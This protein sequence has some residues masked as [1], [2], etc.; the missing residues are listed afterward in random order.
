[1]TVFH[2]QSGAGSAAA[3]A[4]PA[5]VT[6]IASAFRIPAPVRAFEFAG[7]GNIN[8]QTY[9]VLDANGREYLLQRI[10][11]HV[12]RDPHSVMASM[13]ASIAAQN[14]NLAENNVP[15]DLTW[16]PIT[17][18]GARSGRPYLDVED[19]TLAGVW[20]LMVRIS[21]VL[22]VKSLSEIRSHD[23]RLKVA[24]EAGRGLAVYGDLTADMETAG[25]RSPLPGYRDTRLY[26]DQLQAALRECHSVEQAADLLPRDASLRASTK[27]LYLVDLDA[28]TYAERRGDERVCYMVDVAQRSERFAMTLLR[29]MDLGRIRRT[30]IHGDTKLENFLLDPH[31]LQVRA[32]I[33]LDTILPHTWLADWGDMVRSLVN[34]AGEKEP[35]MSCVDVD[36][37]IYEAVARGFL[38]AARRVTG[39]EVSLMVEAVEIIALELGVRFLTDYLRGDTYFRVGPDDPVDLNRTRALVQFTLFERLR[40]LAPQA[41]V[42]INKY[43]RF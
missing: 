8:Q 28:D 24:A 3:T 9:M 21:D 38:G 4:A 13:M 19:G 18:I 41:R 29:E 17:L 32:L 14:R 26:Y 34:V 25:L 31:T 42:I 12:F 15:K 5:A 40:E 35:D 30:A 22:T 23:E 39:A 1:M 11:D 20:R 33:D 37:E 27:H 6:E 7:K 36:M 10:N 16:E 2:T 43:A